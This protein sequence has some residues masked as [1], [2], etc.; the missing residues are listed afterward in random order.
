MI[1]V[2]RHP[3]ADHFTLLPNAIARGLLPVPLRCLA[4]CMLIPLLS[5][6]AGWEI[7]RAEINRAFVE[8]REA[9][10]AG[11]RQLREAGYLRQERGHDEATGR[12]GWRSRSTRA[13]PAA[14]D[15]M[16]TVRPPLIRDNSPVRG[17]GQLSE[18]WAYKVV[19]WMNVGDSPCRSDDILPFDIA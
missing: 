17:W 5:L 13:I 19:V 1:R 9:V 8:G 3:P 2:Y 16:G 18:R 7:T 12:L 15:E 14:G 4:R 10:S 6:P 11:I